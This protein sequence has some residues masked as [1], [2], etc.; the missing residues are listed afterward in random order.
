V[1]VNVVLA[2][3]GQSDPQGKVHLIGAGWSMTAVGPKGLTPDSCVAVFLEVPWDKCNRELPV[4]VQ[5][6]DEDGNAVIIHTPAGDQPVH[7][8][9]PLVIATIPGAPNGSPG[10]GA[11]VL[12]L[13]G[14]LPLAPGH[15]YTWRVSVDSELRDDW[16][17]RFFVQRLPGVPTLG[18][19]PG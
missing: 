13:Q 8:T 1:K 18:G 2:D 4:E 15:W 11:V 7:L 10:C 17:A 14:G 5:L 9:N 6:V 19:A 12:N 3:Y 16:S